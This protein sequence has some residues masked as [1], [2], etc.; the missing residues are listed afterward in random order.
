MIIQDGI[1]DELS[2]NIIAELRKSGTF[3]G[4]IEERMHFFLEGMWDKLEYALKDSKKSAGQL[5]ECSD[6]RVVQSVFNGRTLNTI[7]WPDL[8][9]VAQKYTRSQQKNSP[10]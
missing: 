8:E 3:G 5:E 4:F 7:F 1:V 9:S 10:E 6:S 2:G